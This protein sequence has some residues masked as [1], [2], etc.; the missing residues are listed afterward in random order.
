MSG[1]PP[2]RLF[3]VPRIEY[4][5]P[6]FTH[7]ELPTEKV[8]YFLVLD[9]EANNNEGKTSLY[10]FKEIIEFPV[11]KVNA[12]TL[13]TESE[14]HTYVMPIAY[15]EINPFIT[16]LCGITQDMVDSK[17]HLP[18]VL[19]QLD[20]WMTREGLLE[21]RVK[22]CFVTC[23]DWDL[24]QALPVNCDYLKLRYRDYLKRWIDISS[25]FKDITGNSRASMKCM[26]QHFGLEQDG[27]DHSGIDDSRNTV[28]I[29]HE[30]ARR[31][32]SLRDGCVAPRVLVRK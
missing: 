29:L 24:Q 31:S 20:E 3:Q 10:A 27:R 14:F 9:F 19:K 21:A 22:F 17:P 7:E 6:K 30:L 32:K 16:K 15:P 8:D 26:L 1:E 23:G 13:Q 12:R 18:D 11:L 28:K 2:S 25:Y 5:K 4:D